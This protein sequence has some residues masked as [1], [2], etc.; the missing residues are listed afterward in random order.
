MARSQ[1]SMVTGGLGRAGLILSLLGSKVPGPGRVGL[2]GAT[3]YP[4]PPGMESPL[5]G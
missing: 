1:C 4:R 2:W 3:C 5:G